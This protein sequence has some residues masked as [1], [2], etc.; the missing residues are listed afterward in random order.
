LNDSGIPV[1]LAQVV[2]F[3]LE[4]EPQQGLFQY[5]E[6]GDLFKTKVITG[7]FHAR[8]NHNP[9]NALD[10]RVEAILINKPGGPYS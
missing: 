4:A 2:Y 8:Q 6:D 9:H 7:K 5:V 10:G 3:L 1:I